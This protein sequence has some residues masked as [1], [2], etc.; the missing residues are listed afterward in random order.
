MAYQKH[1]TDMLSVVATPM[2]VHRILQYVNRQLR[3]INAG[4]KRTSLDGDP[5]SGDVEL[6]WCSAVL[7]EEAAR[8][9]DALEPLTQLELARRLTGLDG[10]SLSIDLSILNGLDALHERHKHVFN[11]FAK[12]SP[13]KLSNSSSP[14][15]LN[16]DELSSVDDSRVLV[17]SSRARR[18]GSRHALAWLEFTRPLVAVENSCRALRADRPRRK[19]MVFGRL[20]QQRF[21][22]SKNQSRIRQLDAIGQIRHSRRVRFRRRVSATHDT[23]TH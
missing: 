19:C 22:A 18:N 20:E 23:I 15:K 14:V 21:V 11:A 4:V 8:E 9:S 3:A 12:H 17:Q 13:T 5:G 6:T 10:D 2:Q 1:V 16:A 7:L